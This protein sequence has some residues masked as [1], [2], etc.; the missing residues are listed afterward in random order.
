MQDEVTDDSPGPAVAC[1]EPQ[2][3]VGREEHPPLLF[4][5]SPPWSSLQMRTEDS[6]R[7]TASCSRH[8]ARGTPAR[9]E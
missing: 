7:G 6:E 4:R 3:R 9:Q 2:K 5:V 1:G 8:G